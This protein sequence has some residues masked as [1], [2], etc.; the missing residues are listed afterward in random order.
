VV[1][2]S[3]VPALPGASLWKFLFVGLAS[4]VAVNLLPD[5]LFL[6][7]NR[8]TAELAGSCL[9]LFGQN[10]SVDGTVICV[11]S[12]RAQV[13]TEC[14][15][16]F[17]SILFS[18]FLVAARAT[19]GERLAGFAVGTAV[20]FSAD[21]VRIA[22]V[23][24]AGGADSRLFPFMHVYLGQVMMVLLVGGMSSAWM[25]WV[26]TRT[27]GVSTA[28]FAMRLAVYG[29]ILFVMWLPV[30]HRYVALLD[31]AVTGFLALAGKTVVI[32]LR[33]EIYHHT[34]SLVVF[35]ALVLAS[36]GIAPGRRAAGLALGVV[37]LATVHVL[38]RLNQVVVVMWQPAGLSRLHPLIHVANQYLLP[39]LLWL[40]V[41]AWGS[42][43]WEGDGIC[44]FCPPPDSGGDGGGSL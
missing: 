4:M 32:P 10:A 28:G 3:A 1:R 21:V 31:R 39:L 16:L 5:S 42:A 7:L 9:Q 12:F 30:H 24:A 38:F 36:S 22:A 8:V 18:A 13:I 37:L 2:A 35:T 23:V 15:A 29:S 19:A 25:K 33:P 6:P 11:G 40:A 43:R 44:A 27:G 26:A 20:L 34:L 41:L 14:T 17:C